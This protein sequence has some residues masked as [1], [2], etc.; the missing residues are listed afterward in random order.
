LLSPDSPPMTIDTLLAARDAIRSKQ[1]SAVELTKQTLDRIER[2][3]PTIQA[4]NEVARDLALQQA[5]AVDAGQ[6]TGPLAGV[7]LAIKDNLC[8]TWG[9]TT[10]SSKML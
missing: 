5:Q 1:I 10:C 4:F 2:L 3:D 6:R 9:K 8:T 7:P